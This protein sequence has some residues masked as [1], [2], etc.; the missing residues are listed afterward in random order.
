MAQT[1]HDDCQE[2]SHVAAGDR[3]AANSLGNA[4]ARTSERRRRVNWLSISPTKRLRTSRE[5]LDCWAL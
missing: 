4:E 5:C 2:A 3:R 1:R